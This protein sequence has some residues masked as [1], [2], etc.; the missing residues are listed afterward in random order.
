MPLFGALFDKLW[1]NAG[2]FDTL[3]QFRVGFKK[4]YLT[5]TVLHCI[6][7]APDQKTKAPCTQG[8]VGAFEPELTISTVFHFSLA[9]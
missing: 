8:T 2:I 9:T 7:L 1:D 3:P 6:I 5:H 4:I